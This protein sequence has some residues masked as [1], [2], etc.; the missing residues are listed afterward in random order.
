MA[1]G[2]KHIA[3]SLGVSIALVSRVLSGQAREI[4]IAEKTIE[5]VEKMAREVGYVPNAA[6]LTLKGKSTRTIGVAVY[7]FTDPYFDRLIQQIQIQ[8]HERNYSIMLAG[9]LNRVPDDQD[10]QALHKHAI[11]GLIVLGSELDATWPATFHHLPIA[12]IGLGSPSENSVRITIDEEDAARKLI[13]HL[14]EKGFHNLASISSLLATHGLRQNAIKREAE[15]AGMNLNPI[16]SRTLDPFSAGREVASILPDLMQN[17]DA[18][19]CTSDQTAMGVLHALTDAGIKSP[20]RIAVTGFDDIPAGERFI[21]SI[22]TIRQPFAEMV[23]HAF[24]AILSPP[25]DPREVL[26][27]GSLVVRKTT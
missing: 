27:P 1:V 22:T 8:A 23:R 4:G 10:L 14:Q 9:F 20:G 16:A 19:V 11:D 3:E 2:Q 12:R 18:M 17:T 5:R 21:P 25:I 7:D 26:L 6:A 15:K 24:E 13:G